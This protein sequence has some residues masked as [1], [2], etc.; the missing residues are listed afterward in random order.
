M[1][2]C[3]NKNVKRITIQNAK[4]IMKRYMIPFWNKNVSK[5]MKD[6]KRKK[7]VLKYRNKYLDKYRSNNARK[8]LYSNA[9]QRIKR[10][11]DQI[12]THFDT[13]KSAI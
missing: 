9:I 12:I 5:Y 7:N 1:K 4:P 13:K 3:K 10:H 11:C 2:P 8:F 6:T